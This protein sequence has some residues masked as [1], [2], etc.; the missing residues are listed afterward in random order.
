MLSKKSINN[1]ILFY[2]KSSTIHCWGSFSQAL[3][4]V[5]PVT[6]ARPVDIVPLS[7][8]GHLAETNAP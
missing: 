5:G 6:E 1:K 3:L 4:C 8:I 7:T 2:T